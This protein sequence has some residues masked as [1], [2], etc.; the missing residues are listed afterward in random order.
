MHNGQK[1]KCKRKFVLTSELKTWE[2]HQIFKIHISQCKVQWVCKVQWLVTTSWILSC[3]KLTAVNWYSIGYCPLLSKISCNFLY[4]K[5]N[6]TITTISLLNFKWPYQECREPTARGF[7][8]RSPSF[9]PFHTQS[10]PEYSVVTEDKLD[11]LS[12][13]PLYQPLRGRLCTPT[14][15]W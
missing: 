8:V 14:Q 2:V 13:R 12:T 3:T 15:C 9:Y 4:Y 5:L 7:S 10:T 1:V 6:P 11:W